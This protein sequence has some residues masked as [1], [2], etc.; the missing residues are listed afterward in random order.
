LQTARTY[1]EV[2]ESTEP[3]P[4]SWCMW[5]IKENVWEVRAVREGSKRG[6]ACASEKHLFT[7]S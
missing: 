3:G 5:E 1:E 4:S 6:S 2:M 7:T